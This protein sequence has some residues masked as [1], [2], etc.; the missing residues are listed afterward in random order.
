ML[1]EFKNEPSLDFTLE[2]NAKKQLE[3][4]QM[5]QSRLGREYDLLIGAERLKGPKTFSSI[6]PG[7]K[8]QIVGVFQSASADQAIQA[9]EVA[10]EAFKSWSRVP[11]QDR[12]ELL[13]RAAHLLRELCLEGRS[14]LSME[15][16]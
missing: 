1:P 2:S 16:Q 4:L 11:V 9:V 5:V 3:A 14:R 15:K 10:S 7:K 6:N 12:A 13:F 8:S